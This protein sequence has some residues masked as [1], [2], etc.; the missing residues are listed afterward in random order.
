MVVMFTRHVCCVA[1]TILLLFVEANTLAIHKRR[2]AYKDTPAVCNAANKTGPHPDVFWLNLDHSITRREMLEVELAR[3]GLLM[4]AS[5]IRALTPNM[6]IVPED[7]KL[8]HQC[9]VLKKEQYVDA[10]ELRSKPNG[11]V[12]IDAL[13]GRPRNSK[14]E[15]AVTA[16][17]LMA[18]YTAVNSG[19]SSPYALILEDDIEFPF[20]IDFHAL[21]AS[22]PKGF[23]ILQLI[24]SNDKLLHYLW[25]K[26]IR[27]NG[28]NLVCTVDAMLNNGQRH[29]ASYSHFLYIIQSNKYSLFSL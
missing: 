29:F 1:F 19:S 20:D 5:R 10:M 13:C 2:S 22:A 11:R 21:A 8:P 12:F 23:A 24:T 14:K 15:L 26:Y 9:V 17:H 6:L 27:S 3:T 25:K 16:S 28:Q 7:L 18:L 4:G